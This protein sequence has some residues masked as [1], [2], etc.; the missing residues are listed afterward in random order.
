MQIKTRKSHKKLV[1][2]DSARFYLLFA[3]GCERM[4]GAIPFAT[5]T[6][7]SYE[8]TLKIKSIYRLLI[9]CSSS[10][11]PQVFMLVCF[12]KD[13]AKVMQKTEATKFSPPVLVSGFHF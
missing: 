3:Q 2:G 13:G 12:A 11:H 8:N 5:I 7:S 1:F 4:F 9:V 6:G 10:A